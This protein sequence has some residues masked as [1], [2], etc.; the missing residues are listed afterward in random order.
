MAHGLADW[1]VRKHTTHLHGLDIEMFPELFLGDLLFKFEAPYMEELNRG[2]VTQRTVLHEISWKRVM[3]DDRAAVQMELRFNANG[4]LFMTTLT[5]TKSCL[6]LTS[7]VTR[8]SIRTSSTGL[9][10]LTSSGTECYA[11]CMTK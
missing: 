6:P 1:I 8:H 7:W 4:E 5:R 9:C 2:A 3:L 11:K 10:R